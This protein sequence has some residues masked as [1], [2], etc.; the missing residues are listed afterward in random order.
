MMYATVI[1][2]VPSSTRKRAFRPVHTR[3]IERIRELEDE[4]RDTVEFREF[5]GG[6]ERLMTPTP[7]AC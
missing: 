3:P 1:S 4:F 7:A 2:A 6:V 5:V